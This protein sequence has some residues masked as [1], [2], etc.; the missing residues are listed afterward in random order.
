VVEFILAF[1]GVLGAEAGVR[2]R[3]GHAA[4]T[5]ASSALLTVGHN[6]GGGN[7]GARVFGIHESSF[8]A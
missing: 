4:T 2:I 8:L 6:G 1:G 7:S 3:N 5:S